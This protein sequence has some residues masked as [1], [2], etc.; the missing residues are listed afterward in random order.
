MQSHWKLLYF[1]SQCLFIT[2][3]KVW[4]VFQPLC[5]EWAWRLRCLYLKSTM[6][7]KCIGSQ[8]T[9]QTLCSVCLVLTD[10]SARFC[11]PCVDVKSC[12][13]FSCPVCSLIASVR[14][15]TH[16]QRSS[17]RTC[18]R[19]GKMCRSTTQKILQRRS[20]T[21]SC[22]VSATSGWLCDLTILH[23]CGVGWKGP[24]NSRHL[25]NFG[26]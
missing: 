6:N 8:L 7:S 26:N 13:D 5:T 24:T 22:A 21:L 18:E 19:A 10:P 14:D 9:T 23:F 25:G 2:K 20:D 16:Q 4:D 3:Y 17:W 15:T 11:V 12:S 1:V